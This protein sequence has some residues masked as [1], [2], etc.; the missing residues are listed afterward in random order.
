MSGPDEQNSNLALFVEELGDQL[1]LLNGA[2]LD[3]EADS[4]S[5]GSRDS[6]MRAAHTVKGAARMVGLTI[7]ERLA[8]AI[9]DLD[10]CHVRGFPMMFRIL[11]FFLFD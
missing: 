6:L 11:A 9:E 1:S 10:G 5:S 4:A 2:L 3:L 8:H 7:L